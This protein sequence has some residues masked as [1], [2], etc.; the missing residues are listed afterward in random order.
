MIHTIEPRIGA[1]AGPLRPSRFWY[2]VAGGLLVAAAVC[3]MIA[4]IGM[5]SWDRQIQDFQ[6]VPVPGRG[7]VTLTQPGD[8]VVYVET[9]GGCCAWSVGS[10]NGPPAGWSLR[11][12]LAPANGG[13]TIR[14]SNWTGLPESY[15][16]SGHQGQAAMSFTI[17][18]PGTYLIATTDVHPAAVTD[19]AVGRNILRATLLPLF[20]LIAGLA[21]LLGAA[22]SFV[23]TMVQRSRAR[24]GT[25]APPGG[26][27]PG[28][29]APAGSAPVR[30]TFAGAARQ[31]RGTVLVRAILAIPA[32]IGLGFVRFAARLVLVTAWFGALFTGRLPDYA[33]SF[34]AWSQRWEVRT[35]AYL[36]LLTDKY[37]AAGYQDDDYPVAVTVSPGRLNRAAVFFRLVLVIPAWCVTTLLGYGLGILMVPTWLIVLIRGRMPRPLYE[38]IAASVR[39]WAQ[40][41]AYWYLL[42]D[43]YPAGLFGDEPGPALSAAFPAFSGAGP[44]P[45][46]HEPPQPGLAAGQPVPLPADY[47]APAAARTAPGAPE[48]L[49][50]SRPGQRL[51]GLIL[52]VGTAPLIALF[53]LFFV[54]ITQA[55]PAGSAPGSAAPRPSASTAPAPAAS[56]G[57][58]PGGGGLAARAVP[59]PA[60]F[61]LSQ[62]ADLHNGPMSAA[63]FNRWTNTSHLAAQLHFIRGYDVTYDSTTNSDSIE[64]TLFQ[65]ATPADATVFK[66]GLLTGGP[67]T[68]RADAV[69]PGADDYDTT[70]PYQGTYDHGVIATTGNLV[71]VI[72]DATGSPAKVPLVKKMARQQYAT[73]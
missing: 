32:L 13:Q 65:F 49:V 16:V 17:T 8:Y 68:S 12:A 50:L 9:R 3:L 48:S 15:S 6:R 61:A 21:A 29:A 23:F 63:G 14:V 55:P 59:A 62:A 5:L 1:A 2:L 33:A 18:R 35:S 27:A 53:A 19:L 67:I 36:L 10:Q 69:I 56:P 31:A 58:I 43:V 30:V 28:S 66:A 34:L 72:D 52:A 7:A 70:S 40:V 24:R 73:L 37:P 4:V 25:G 39:Y 11:L 64:V 44:A 60:G 57:P 41:K 45:G 51:V 20:L 38:A 42:T 54:Q 46:G 26:M 22:V 71:F 47:V